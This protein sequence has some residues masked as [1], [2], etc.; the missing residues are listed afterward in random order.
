V[1]DDR[2]IEVALAIVALAEFAGLIV[3]GLRGR[4]MSRTITRLE[5]A[6][7]ARSAGPRTVAGRA[8]KVVVDTAVKVR[9]QGV[10][11]LLVSSL[12]DLSRWTT[13]DRAEIAKV[14]APDGTVAILFSDIEGSTAHNEQLGDAGWVRVLDVHNTLVRR[15]VG[16]QGGH[17]VKSAGDG[18]MVV[19]GDVRAAARA[20]IGVQSAI[21]TGR[22]RQLRR[23]GVHVRIG[24][25]LGTVVSREGD[26][27]G[28]NVAMAARVAA[29]AQG[30]QILVSDDV[31]DA[32]A[33]AGDGRERFELERWDEVELRGLADLHVLWSLRWQ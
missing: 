8:V 19:F 18:F 17:V 21:A 15:E 33:P 9:D 30:D 26:Y 27:F 3:L 13:E 5:Q 23:H 24:I 32:L 12:E 7:A 31:H 20:A 25:H 6:A 16:K 2:I 1:S 14:V 4:R 28:R 29:H 22:A 11:G 10:G